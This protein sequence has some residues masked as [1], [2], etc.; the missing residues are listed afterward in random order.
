MCVVKVQCESC[1]QKREFKGPFACEWRR[2]F[3]IYAIPWESYQ[4]HVGVTVRE[5][6]RVGSKHS[7]ADITKELFIKKYI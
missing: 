6:E 2:L 5:T 1:I 3:L 7:L 4:L